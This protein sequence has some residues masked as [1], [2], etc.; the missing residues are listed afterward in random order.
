MPEPAFA[1]LAAAIA[2][3]RAVRHFGRIAAAGAATVTVAGL[4]AVTALGDRV[5]IEARTGGARAGEVLGLAPAGAA[6]LPEGPAEGLAIGDRVEHLGPAAIAPDDGWI[7]R[8]V[9]PAG[10]PLDG[11]P[12]HAGREARPLRAPAP[13]ATGRRRLGPRLATGL[14]VFDTL[15]PIVRGQR[16]G[17][18]AGSGVGKSML[19]ARLARGLAAD[20]AVIALVGERGRELREFVE[21]TLGPEGLARAVIVTATSDAP[22]LARRR[23]AWAGMAVAEHFRDGGAHVLFLCDSVTRFAEAHREIALAA[24]EGTGLG[25][26]PASTAHLIG[27]LA[28]RAGPGPEGAG[29]ITAVFSVLVPGSDMEE[30]VADILRG[31]LDGHVVLDRAIAERGRFPA[32]DLLRSVSRSLPAAATA[33]EGA[34]IAEARRLLGAWERAEMMVRA[35]LYAQGSDPLVD[36]AIRVF[37]R[38]DAFLAEAAPDGPAAAFRGLAACLA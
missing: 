14:A 19:L 27:A 24:G 16:I 33:E 35:G 2:R 26:W 15:L 31:V 22:P 29:D 34:L 4:P 3:V 8:I 12:L 38:L 10:A 25:G 6:V 9:D 1:P 17:L 30:P 18:F 13:P 36:A 37:P 20:V 21:G 28:E 5:R 23:A 7:G 11:R 32:V